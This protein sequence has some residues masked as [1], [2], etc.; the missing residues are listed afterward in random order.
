MLFEE[1]ENYLLDLHRKEKAKLTIEK[2]RH[3]IM[4]ML[5]YCGFKGKTEISKEQLLFYK[6]YLME[7]RAPATINA[8]IAAING[9]LKYLGRSDLCLSPL[10][11]QRAM[12]REQS[13]ELSREEYLRL[14]KAAEKSD[15]QLAYIVQTICSTGIRV[16]ELRF[17]TIHAVRTGKAVIQN[18]GK[19]RTVFL[20]T[21]LCRLL[22][23]YCKKHRI[24][25][26]VVFLDQKGKPI[27]RFA[28]WRRMKKLCALAGVDHC[29]VFPHNLRHLFAVC[30]YQMQHD[31]EHLA[32]IL[33]HS[34]INT[35]RIYM[36]TSGQEHQKQLDM[37][38]LI[39]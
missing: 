24:R 13:K 14:L 12:Y 25:D 20:P 3:D 32:T 34:S 28:V 9:F 33:G 7:F 22:K 23:V 27:N 38:R 31:I 39:P 1:L 11:V 5:V 16:S 36:C 2:Y 26:G 19:F 6:E 18:K 8:A 35:T 37:L 4:K 21:K 10:K 29:K 30:F 15:E 17:I